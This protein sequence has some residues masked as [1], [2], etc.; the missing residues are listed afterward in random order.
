MNASLA[1]TLVSDQSMGNFYTA[2]SAKVLAPGKGRAYQG[3]V[4]I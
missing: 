4:E 3:A 2:G 1:D